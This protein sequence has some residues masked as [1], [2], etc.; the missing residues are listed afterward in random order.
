[1]KLPIAS[2]TGV[3]KLTALHS[4]QYNAANVASV[5]ETTAAAEKWK[6]HKAVRR[7]GVKMMRVCLRLLCALKS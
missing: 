3:V 7:D 4:N 1:M 2:L 5:T 6:A